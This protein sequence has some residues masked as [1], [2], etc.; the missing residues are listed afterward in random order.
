MGTYH[1]VACDLCRYTDSYLDGVIAG[2]YTPPR[3]CD[4]CE[5]ITTGWIPN[6]HAEP[7]RERRRSRFD[8]VA[9]DRDGLC[10]WCGEPAPRL[11]AGSPCPRCESGRLRVTVRAGLIVD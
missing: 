3:V 4:G 5:R 10:A 11:E 6:P 1:D 2:R 8:A 9:C 7:V